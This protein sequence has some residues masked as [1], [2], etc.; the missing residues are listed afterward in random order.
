MIEFNFITFVHTFTS[1]DWFGVKIRIY[2]LLSRNLFS[3]LI[4][5]HLI[6]HSYGHGSE[7][8]AAAARLAD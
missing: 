8:D 1:Y 2:R 3:G 4:T 7:G 6:S 5:A